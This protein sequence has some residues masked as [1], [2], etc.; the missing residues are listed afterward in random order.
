M[1]S[2]CLELCQMY[3][4]MQSQAHFTMLFCL[5]VS[6]CRGHQ[7]GAGRDPSCHA[8]IVIVMLMEGK[9]TGKLACQHKF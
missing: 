9:E 4:K 1:L 8:L 7:R 5:S 2:R 3:V 6:G